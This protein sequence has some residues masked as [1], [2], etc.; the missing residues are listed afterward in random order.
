MLILTC[1]PLQPHAIGMVICVDTK[2]RGPGLSPDPTPR[3]RSQ[4]VNSNILKLVYITSNN[5]W[6]NGRAVVRRRYAVGG[7]PGVE[8]HGLQTFLHNNHTQTMSDT[9]RPWIGP[10]VLIPFAIQQTRVAP[11]STI[12]NQSTS[13]MSPLYGRTVLPR[14]TVRT[15]RTGTVS[16]K[17]FCLFSLTNRSRYLLH[18]ESV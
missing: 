13:A 11:D 5:P 15:V 3:Q 10:R 4:Q 9:W 2:D 18:T 14:Q 8:P 1:Q 7:G 6:P 12:A 16:I 17:F